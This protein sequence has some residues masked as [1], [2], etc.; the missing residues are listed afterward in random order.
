MYH[1]L[2][3]VDKS[4]H[5]LPYQMRSALVLLTQRSFYDDLGLTL[6]PGARLRVVKMQAIRKAAK[7][8]TNNAPI[9][10]VSQSLFAPHGAR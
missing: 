3:S 7:N 5:G 8:A 4:L 9:P 2:G 1:A 10:A 6:T